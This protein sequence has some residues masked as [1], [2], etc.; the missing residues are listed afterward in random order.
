MTCYSKDML[1]L[2]IIEAIKRYSLFNRGDRII[3]ACSGG[4]DSVSLF[5]VLRQL[6]NEWDFDLLIGHYNH[7]LRREADEDQDFVANL[8][9]DHSLPFYSESGDVKA[10]AQKNN[11]NLEQAGRQLRYGFLKKI[12]RKHG[13]AKIATGHTMTDQAETVLMRILRGTGPQG[14]GG[15]RP[16][17]KEGIVRPLILAKREEVQR[18]IEKK[19]LRY[20][21]DESNFDMDFLRNKIRHRLIPYMK[22]NYS[23]HI[24]DHLSRLASIIQEEDLFLQ[25]ISRKKEAQS[26]IKTRGQNRLDMDFLHTLY[27]ALQRRVVREYLAKIRGDLRELS[28]KDIQSIIDL[29]RGKEFHLEKDL[30]L[31]N[32]NGL[33]GIKEESPKYKYEY[34]WSEKTPLIIK[35]IGITIKGSR[36]KKDTFERDF[37]NRKKVFL[38]SSKLKFPLKVRNRQQGDRYRPLGAPGKQKLKELM[39]AK[40][41]PE[42]SRDKKPVFVSEHEIV[43]VQ[44]LPVSENHKVK[45]STKN[46]FKIEIFSQK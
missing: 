32:E 24:V 37:D 16:K 12:A 6:K 46:I 23:P 42:S 8:A 34:I 35:E 40:R 33:V 4:A 13:S 29:R 43:W 30:F 28:Y 25:D 41:I 26:E 1:L 22:N 18:Y 36:I 20:R 19:N 3:I 14:L 27:P 11:M 15:M 5:H 39:R 17:T 7:K 44:D 9:S 21:V 38:D 10:Y 45:S 31:N 2:K